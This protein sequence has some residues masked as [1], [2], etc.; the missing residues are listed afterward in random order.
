MRRLQS[1]SSITVAGLLVGMLTGVAG[2]ALAQDSLEGLD[3]EA[4]LAIRE[5][6]LKAK[7][8]ELAER[9]AEIAKLEASKPC[10][11]D[12]LASVRYGPP[13]PGDIAPE[14]IAGAVSESDVPQPVEEPVQASPEVEASST[15]NPDEVAQT[16]KAMK[17]KKAARVVVELDAGLA[18]QAMTQLSARNRARILD[19][20]PPPAAASITA[21]LGETP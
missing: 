7:E 19:H 9:E 14:T 15:G 21:A 6:Q 2:V 8:A 20:V 3:P 5:A 1:I 10:D 13:I 16:L 18:A 11:I 17:P 12:P 4:A